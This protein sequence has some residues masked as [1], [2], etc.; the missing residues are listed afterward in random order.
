MKHTIDRI[1]S[2]PNDYK[3]CKDCGMINWYEN[4][5]CIYCGSGNFNK[6]GADIKEWVEDGAYAEA[7]I[8]E[9]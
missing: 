7:D 5:T 9:V 2:N 4:K 6:I 8:L 1:L 3:L